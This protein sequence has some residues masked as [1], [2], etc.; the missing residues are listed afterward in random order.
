MSYCTTTFF[1]ATS[2]PQYMSCCPTTV[3]ELLLYCSTTVYELQLLC[4]SQAVCAVRKLQ[5]SRSSAAAEREEKLSVRQTTQPNPAQPTQSLTNNPTPLTLHPVLPQPYPAK[6]I[7]H[8]QTNL[9]WDPDFKVI[10]VKAYDRPPI[11]PLFASATLYWQT[12]FPVRHPD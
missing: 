8:R 10:L 11:L 1:S 9:V 2:I 12:S 4:H 5:W 3:Y 7:F 6:H